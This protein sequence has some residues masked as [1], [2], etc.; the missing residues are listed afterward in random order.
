MKKIGIGCLVIFIASVLIGCHS[1]D[2][3][4]DSQKE[5]ETVF[6]K[7]MTDIKLFQEVPMMTVA[8]GKT[9][10]VGDMGAGNQVITING[11][12]L[13]EYWTY[14]EVLEETG[15]E[16]YYDNGKEGLRGDV[17][18][19][20]MTKEDLV[21]T[22]IHMLKTNLTYIVAE[23]D[24]PLS[25]R[26]FYKEDYIAENK[27]GGK[28][29]LHMVELSDF[30]NSFVIQLKNGHFILNDGGREEDLPYLLDYLES[31]APKGEKPVIEA[32]FISHPHEDHAELFQAFSMN[33]TYPERIYV[34]A[35]YM[36]LVNSTVAT[37]M[38]VA[39]VQMAVV[40]MSKRLKTTD[41]SYPKIYRPQAGQTYYFSDIK[42]EVMQTMLQIPEESWYKWN[43]NINEFST[44]LMYNIEGQTF[45]NAGDGDFGSMKAIMR[46]YDKE[47]FE[48]DIMAVQHHGINVRN[49]F[50]D[51]I[52]VKTLVYPYF[53]IDG[54]WK[55]GHSWQSEA[56]NK[57]LH[58]KALESITYLDGTQVMTFPYK[59]GTTKSLGHS[60]DRADFSHD[61]QRIQ[62]Y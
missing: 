20:T 12:E 60:R 8:N 22:V 39:G 43:Q 27:E 30:G 5:V 35:I 46:T 17:Y 6:Y 14:L 36:D 38:S 10:I 16:R 61:A 52:T 7:E 54:M 21:I 33:I 45:L 34:E 55:S 18:S 41:G 53:G 3:S 28:T 13:E 25:E 48:M 59:V 49:E 40:N 24:I 4:V 50:T 51:F 23:D 26:L 56:E 57:Y 19:A 62:Y 9:K 47:D 1:V 44:W 32:W 11:S 42:V 2:E 15:F 29:T 31:L 37:N 58:E